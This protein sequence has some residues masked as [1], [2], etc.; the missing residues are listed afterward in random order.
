M[1]RKKLKKTSAPQVRWGRT[2]MDVVNESRDISR[3][4]GQQSG[5][6]HSY[7]KKVKGVVVGRTTA[8]DS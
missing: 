5:Q 7:K 1:P 4:G 2:F 3:R 8:A 6:S